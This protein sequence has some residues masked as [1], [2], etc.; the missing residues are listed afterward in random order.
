MK[1]EVIPHA[2]TKLQNKIHFILIYCNKKKTNLA[3]KNNFKK[4]LQQ[5]IHRFKIK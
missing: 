2:N 4:V 5:V 1:C 3:M